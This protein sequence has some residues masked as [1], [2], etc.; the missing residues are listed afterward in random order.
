MRRS[1]TRTVGWGWERAH[2]QLRLEPHWTAWALKIMWRP[3]QDLVAGGAYIRREQAQKNAPSKMIVVPLEM[4]A[5]KT[6]TSCEQSP[7]HGCGEMR[8]V[9]L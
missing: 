5:P 9:G 3:V 4:A 8:R 2:S 1:T 6:L 7:R